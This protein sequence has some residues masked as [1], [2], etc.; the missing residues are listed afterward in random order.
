MEV[1]NGVLPSSKPDLLAGEKDLSVLYCGPDRV[2]LGH[3]DKCACLSVED[4]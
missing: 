1:C 2:V 4:S 3:G